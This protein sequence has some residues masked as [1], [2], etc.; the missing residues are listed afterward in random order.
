MRLSWREWCEPKAKEKR[1]G[2]NRLEK[3]DEE[4]QSP[5]PS[6]SRCDSHQ[7]GHARVETGV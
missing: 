5:R 3:L 2:R 6:A 4:V 7:C 1:R